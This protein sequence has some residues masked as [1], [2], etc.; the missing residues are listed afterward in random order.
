M[1]SPAIPVEVTQ[2]GPEHCDTLAG[3]E[4]KVFPTLNPDEWFTADMYRAH[5]EVFPEGQMVA[6]TPTDAGPRVIGCTTTFRTS[7][8]FEGDA[9]PYYFEFIGHG[10]LTTHEPDSPWLYGV[11][12]FVDPD[13]HRKGV[14]SALYAARRA[15]VRRLNLRGEVVAGL[16]PGYIRYRDQMT[17][18]EYAG[19]V[20]R[21]ELTDPT[22][23]MQL[24]NGFTVRR[25]LHGFIHD[26]RSGDTATLMVRENPDWRG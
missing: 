13:Y 23:T 20:I 21:G 16:M 5:V 26:E 14:G 1:S 7:E 25:L 9:P 22:L 18:D 3:L 6:W 8:S 15:L 11:G 10:Y 19:R 2:T 12:L 4:Q 17:V 24:R